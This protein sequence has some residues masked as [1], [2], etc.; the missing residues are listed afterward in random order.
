M[1]SDVVVVPTEL[2][3]VV[4]LVGSALGE[5]TTWWTFKAVGVGASVYDASV[6]SG[7]D[8]SS[9]TGADLLFGF[10]GGD[11]LFGDGVVFGFAHAV[12]EVDGVGPHSAAAKAG[13]ALMAG[14]ASMVKASSEARSA[15]KSN[16]SILY[17]TPMISNILQSSEIQRNIS[18]QAGFE[19]KA[20]LRDRTGYTDQFL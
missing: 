19:Q 2:C 18:A 16:I 8:S 10:S 12:D 3:Q 17:N 11:A 9:Q 15:M 1:G 20:C 13:S 4:C 14:L 6:A 5:G 7:E